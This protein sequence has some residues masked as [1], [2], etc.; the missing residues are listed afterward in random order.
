[1]ETIGKAIKT[2]SGYTFEKDF[3]QQGY[4]YKYLGDLNL[5]DDNY[6]IYSAEY[7][8]NDYETKATLQALCKDSNINWLFLFE[9]L[10]WQH[11]DGLFY[12]LEEGTDWFFKGAKE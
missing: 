11:A 1:M 4:V 9:M 12:E 10:D 8:D 3:Y 5:I 2:N 6:P 7:Q